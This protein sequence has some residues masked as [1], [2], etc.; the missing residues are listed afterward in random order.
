M[1]V[2]PFLKALV[3]INV[4]ESSQINIRYCETFLHRLVHFHRSSP[5]TDGSLCEIHRLL[6]KECFCN[7]FA[8]VACLTFL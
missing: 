8:H 1:E 3:E 7:I 4:K 6:Q 5:F 2:L